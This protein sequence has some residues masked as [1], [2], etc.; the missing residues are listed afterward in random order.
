[1][2]HLP[3]HQVGKGNVGT[4]EGDME[5]E[6]DRAEMGLT[7]WA[8]AVNKDRDNRRQPIS[9]PIPHLGGRN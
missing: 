2:W 7:S 5:V 8:A 3:G 4:A 9:V 1:M 6:K